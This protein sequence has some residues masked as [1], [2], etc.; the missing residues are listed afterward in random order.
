MDVTTRSSCVIEDRVYHQGERVEV[1]EDMTH[2]FKGHRSMSVFD[3]PKKCFDSLHGRSR[4]S[5]SV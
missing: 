3:I 4:N 2:E 1:V 5:I